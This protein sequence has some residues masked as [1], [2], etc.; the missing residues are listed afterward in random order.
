MRRRYYDSDLTDLGHL[1]V[2]EELISIV[3][4]ISNIKYSFIQQS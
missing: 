4:L 3:R 1:T 2:I